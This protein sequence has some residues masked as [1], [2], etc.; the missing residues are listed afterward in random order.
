M[1][2]FTLIELLVVIAIIAIL[3]AMLLPALNKARMTAQKSSCQGNLKSFGTAFLQYTGDYEDYMPGTNTISGYSLAGWKVTLA[4]YLGI[5]IKL[6]D[7]AADWYPTLSKGV[8]RCPVWR[9]ELVTNTAAQA[10]E[11]NREAGGYG[12]GWPTSNGGTGYVDG[13]G[14]QYRMKITK[15]GIPSETIVYGDNGDGY[16][17]FANSIVYAHGNGNGCDTPT[18]HDKGFNATWVDGHVSHIA[19]AVYNVG[20]PSQFLSA[21]NQKMYYLWAGQK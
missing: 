8:F 20:K 18:R 13:N 1:K 11:G 9:K 16:Q 12:I 3:A 15:V 6:T 10:P 4:P 21:S 14:V 19:T 2:R 5:P 7:T 17:K